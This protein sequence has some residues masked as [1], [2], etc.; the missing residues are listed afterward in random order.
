[1]IIGIVVFFC[2]LMVIYTQ[3]TPSF[4]DSQSLKSQLQKAFPQLKIIEKNG[5]V[6]LCEINHRNEPEELVF[7]RIDPQ[8]EKSIRSF[9]RRVTLTYP[10]YP[11]IKEIKK[12]AMPYIQAY[13]KSS[14]F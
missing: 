3:I 11:S 12:D 9:G 5:T 8:Q 14:K 7:I 6:M 2:I 4:K 1:M 13:L 10:K